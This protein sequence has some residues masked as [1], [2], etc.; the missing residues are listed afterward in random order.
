[1]AQHPLFL[2]FGQLFRAQ[3][4]AEAMQVLE[5]LERQL[6][7]TPQLAWHRANCL[8]KL[9]RF[10]EIP[11]ELDKVLAKSPDYVPAIVKRVRYTPDGD[12]AEEPA[13]EA[14]SEAEQERQQVQRAAR[15]LQASR[16]AEAQL[17]RALALE[18]DNIEALELLAG[19]LRYRDGTDL[20]AEQAEAET[21][22]DRAIELAP[23]RVDLLETRANALRNEALRASLE[24]AAAAERHAPEVLTGFSGMCWHRPSLERALAD[25]ER[26]FALSAHPRYAVRMG[27]VLHD[28]QRF[29]EALL[30]YDQALAQMP[31]D[32]PLRAHVLDLRARSEH[33]GAGE[34]EQMARM[35][36][37]S[38]QAD[39][40]ERSLQ[41]DMAAQA[42]LG[43]AQAVRHGRSLEA[44]LESRVS[45]DP[46]SMMAMNIA[47]QILNAAHESPPELEEVNPSAYPLYQRRFVER[48]GSQI[49][50][51]GL[52]YIGDCEARGLFPMLGQHV[53]IRFFAD[54]AGEVGIAA[55]ALRPKWPGWMGFLVMLLARRWKTHGMLEC[56]S[57]FSDGTHLSTQFESPSPFQYAG[58]VRVETM[59]AGT[60]VKDLVARHLARHAAY[61]AEHPEAMPLVAHDIEGM[62]LRWRE[63]QQVKG[64]Y[65][66]SIGYV[67]DGELR[68]LLGEHYERYADKVRQSLADMATDYA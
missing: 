64:E 5:A 41:D 23:E 14:F 56:V 29:E 15:A 17:R 6:P 24:A 58:R 42:L 47:Q 7:G 53:L 59:P 30:R 36:E 34:R 13:W 66:K 12:T 3:R 4:Y 18:P 45:E 8:E 37:Q 40:G 65:R 49:A 27:M 10:E 25:Y 61:K 39:S 46:D 21:L 16:H 50:P 35:L 2:R 62:D 19:V 67:T 9:E 1:M 55:F 60:P 54:E 51:L 22:L 20:G 52:D 28:L 33:N 32:D 68:K 43:A 31:E 57:Q 44:A 38:L 26:C 63:G 48:I 11:A